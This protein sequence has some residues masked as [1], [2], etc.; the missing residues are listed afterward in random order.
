[1]RI[2]EVALVGQGGHAK[3]EFIDA[4]C[5]EI[6]VEN[7][8]LIFGRLQ[9]NSQLV[10]HL[11]GLD[12]RDGDSN[13]SWDLVSKKLLGYVVLF[14][15]S[16]AQ[17]FEDIKTTIDML[18]SR[19]PLPII[20]AANLANSL[21]ALPAAVTDADFNISRKTHFKFCNTAKPASV[22]RVLVTLIDSVIDK[23]D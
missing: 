5:D 16:S 14:D 10:L 12:H 23:L 1:M 13:P 8:H 4:V 19:Y 6:V 20:V 18:I 3:G 9:I 7:E 21:N 15:W 17:S 11:Y 22:R 2:G